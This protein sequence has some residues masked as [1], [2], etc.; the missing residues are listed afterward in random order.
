MISG[1]ELLQRFLKSIIEQPADEAHIDDLIPVF[2]GI[3]HFYKCLQGHPTPY[4]DITEFIYNYKD[5][6][7]IHDLEILMSAIEL[8]LSEIP[9][10]DRVK[11]FRKFKRHI[12]LAVTQ[13][14]YIRKVANDAFIVAG[15]AE[16]VAS[17]AEKIANKA[18]GI[19]NSAEKVSNKAKLDSQKADQLAERAEKLAEEADAQAKSTIA[20][21]ISILGIFASIIFTLFGGVNLIGSTVKLLETSSRLPYLVFIVS[22]LMICLL[23]LLNMMVKWVNSLSNLKNILESQKNVANQNPQPAHSSWKVWEGDF[24]TKAVSFFMTITVLSLA[25]MYFV[26]KEPFFSFTEEVTSEVK[27]PKGIMSALD[28]PAS[29]VENATENPKGD[30]ALGKAN[31]SKA[32]NDNKDVKVVKTFTFSNH[33]NSSK[34][35]KEDE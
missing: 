20:N 24:Y 12:L 11:C 15:K 22:L 13:K 9:P 5:D 21:Y 17:H 35:E 14:H 8:K 26:K 10:E 25:G 34:D 1:N 29:E 2:N 33:Q 4:H 7:R 3:L 31:D 28:R 19:A 6:I 18:Q 27:E 16:R 32:S 23:T 30:E